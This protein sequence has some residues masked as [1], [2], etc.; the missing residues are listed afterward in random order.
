MAFERLTELSPAYDKRKEGYGIHCVELRMVLK[1]EKGAVQFILFTGWY[2]NDIV[3]NP[4]PADL[5]YHSPY[6][7]YEDQSV[8]SESCEYLNGNPCCYDGSGLNAKRIYKVL[9]EQGSDGVWKEL[10]IYYK[11]LFGD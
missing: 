2:L 4:L 11:E 10:E 7:I 9:L 3:N 8:A 6:P 5:G 1:G